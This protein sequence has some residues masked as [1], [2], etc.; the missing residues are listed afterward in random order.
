MS[1]TLGRGCLPISF[2]GA[3][4]LRFA[5]VSGYAVSLIIALAASPAAA[6]DLGG[7]F[8]V[9]GGATVVSDYRFRGISQTNRRFAIQGTVSVSHS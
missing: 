5:R 2:G 9:N 4:M 8:A 1:R 7:G 3:S 6:E